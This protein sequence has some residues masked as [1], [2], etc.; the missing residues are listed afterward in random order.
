MLIDL[1]DLPPAVNAGPDQ[2][3]VLA[4]GAALNGWALDDGRPAGSW[5]TY[6]W[7]KISGPGTVTFGNAA[8]ATTTA[9]FS[10]AGEYVLR[11]AV[12]DLQLSGYDE[13]TVTATTDADNDGLPDAPTLKVQI[14]SPLEKATIP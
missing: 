8:S 2:S 6:A 4:N 13:V 11:L 7:S 9:A 12:S 1:Y 3:V 5:L 10:A 14:T